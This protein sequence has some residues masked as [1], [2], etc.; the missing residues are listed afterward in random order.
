MYKVLYV[1]NICT[2]QNCVSLACI[3]FGMFTLANYAI[4]EGIVCVQL[5]NIQGFK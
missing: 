4:A 5:N 3:T 2:S 1:F